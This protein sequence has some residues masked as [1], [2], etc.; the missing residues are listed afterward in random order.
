[1]ASAPGWAVLLA[2]GAF[3]VTGAPPFGTFLSELLIL[4]RAIDLHYY[5]TAGLL[6]IGLALA[7]TVICMHIGRVFLGAANSQHSV[8]QTDPDQRRTGH[9][10]GLFAFFGSGDG[11]RHFV[12]RFEVDRALGSTIAKGLKFLS[13]FATPF[14]LGRCKPAYCA[15]NV[16][17]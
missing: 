15:P 2:I 10:T 17:P 14:P 6:I 16:H 7:F 8:F 13:P 5:A 4:M 11:P 9:F 12:G 1:M 3:A